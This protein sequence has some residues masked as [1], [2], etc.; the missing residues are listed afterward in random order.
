MTIIIRVKGFLWNKIHFYE[1]FCILCIHFLFQDI[2]GDVH[3]NEM[4]DDYNAIGR[5]KISNLRGKIAVSNFCCDKSG[6]QKSQKCAILCNQ[7]VFLYTQLQYF[8]SNELGFKEHLT[9]NGVKSLFF[10]LL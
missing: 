2:K 9:F 5:Q 7:H 1:T 6:L 8:E 10:F 4:L 3:T